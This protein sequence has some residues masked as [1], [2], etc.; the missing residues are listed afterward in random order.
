[1]TPA[2][3]RDRKT[4]DDGFDGTHLA[5]L[6]SRHAVTRIALG[7]GMSEMCVAAT[8]RTALARGLGL[9]MPHDGHATYDIGVAPGI[10]DPVPAAMASRV[11]EWSL[12]EEVEIRTMVGFAVQALEAAA[13]L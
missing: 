2:C 8:A 6:L 1:M 13:Q 5:E 4:K 11:A 9:V 12:G 3:A 7:G 10:A